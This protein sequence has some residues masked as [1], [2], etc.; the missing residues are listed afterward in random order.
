MRASRVG[1]VAA[2][3]VLGLAAP[4][5]MH[6]QWGIGGFVGREF[7]EGDHWAILGADARF[8]LQNSPVVINPRFTYHSFGFGSKAIQFDVNVLYDFKLA[9]PGLIR[10]Y[11]GVGGGLVHTSISADLGCDVDCSS[12]TL[13]GDFV[14]GFRLA[15]GNGES[16]IMPFVNSEYSFAKQFTNTY[17]LTVGIIYS[18]K[19]K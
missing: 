2:F 7:D 14:A 8:P 12:S 11:L 5:A 13:V 19:K 9:N 18:P 3:V 4:R 1:Q 16:P 10:P 17:Q 15:F 6:A